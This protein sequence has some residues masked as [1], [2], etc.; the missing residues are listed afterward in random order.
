MVNT[1]EN[2]L[3]AKVNLP[4]PD[5]IRQQIVQNIKQRQLLRQLLRLAEQRRLVE[6]ATTCT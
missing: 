1:A 6:E 4:K 3:L 2:D 5:E